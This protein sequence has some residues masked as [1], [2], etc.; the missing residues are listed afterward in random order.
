MDVLDNQYYLAYG[1]PLYK[2]KVKILMV[3]SSDFVLIKPPTAT[4]SILRIIFKSNATFLKDL[5]VL[6]LRIISIS[7]FSH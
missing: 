6:E 7:A 1:S 2:L 3:L 4:V 5:F